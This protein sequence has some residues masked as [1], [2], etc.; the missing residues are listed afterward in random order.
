MARKHDV[1]FPRSGSPAP[2]GTPFSSPAGVTR[3]GTSAFPG[4]ASRR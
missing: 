3:A 2:A 1:P 4:G